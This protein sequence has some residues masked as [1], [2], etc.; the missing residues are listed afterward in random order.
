MTP[1]TAVERAPKAAHGR[2]ECRTLWA[3]A[4][5]WQSART[6]DTGSAG[7]PWPGV[8]QLL[9]LERR[10]TCPKTGVTHLEVGSAITSL[11]PAKADAARLLGLLRDYWRVENRLHYVR[12]VTMG[13]D[14]CQV[15]CAAAPQALAAC[16]NLTLAL[17]RRAGLANIAEALRTHAAR[18]RA[19]ATLVLGHGL[20]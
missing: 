16:R 9:R 15:R 5:P 20:A 1:T 4:D 2:W 19:A 12:D 13:G 7:R 11:S 14:A 18:P 10:R 8:G 17:L 3:L 6:G